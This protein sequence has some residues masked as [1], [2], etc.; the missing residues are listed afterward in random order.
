[1]WR[2]TNP[3]Y[4]LA[5]D[6]FISA[7]KVAESSQLRVS[8]VSPQPALQRRPAGAAPPGWPGECGDPHLP[9]DAAVLG[10]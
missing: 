8:L 1:L 4:F 7:L 2:V 5:T 9:V 10:L 6:A 3:G